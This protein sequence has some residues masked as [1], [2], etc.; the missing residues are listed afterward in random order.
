MRVLLV[1]LFCLLLGDGEALAQGS[2][3][4]VCNGVCGTIQQIAPVAELLPN[5]PRLLVDDVA[6]GIL[7]DELRRREQSLRLTA[8]E[9]IEIAAALGEKREL[10]ARRAGVEDCDRVGHDKDQSYF[11]KD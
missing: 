4:P 11:G 3:R 5:T 6:A 10:E 8:S 9:K 1:A 7:G 2:P